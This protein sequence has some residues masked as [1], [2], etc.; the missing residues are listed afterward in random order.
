MGNPTDASEIISDPT[1]AVHGLQWGYWPV[2]V[3]LTSILI[4][5]ASTPARTLEVEEYRTAA[6]SEVPTMQI[7]N[8][9]AESDLMPPEEALPMAIKWARWPPVQRFGTLIGKPTAAAGS[10]MVYREAH[11]YYSDSPLG[12]DYYGEHD[13]LVWIVV[14]EGEFDVTCE[15]PGCGHIKGPWPDWPAKPKDEDWI[16]TVVLMMPKPAS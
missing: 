9:E 10:V 13:S 16:Q 8:G 12:K 3:M 1:V 5:C 11:K 14:L 7:N 2:F 4:A 6:P 15:K